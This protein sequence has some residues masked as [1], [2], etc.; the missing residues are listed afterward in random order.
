MEREDMKLQALSPCC[1]GMCLTA[2]AAS[3]WSARWDHNTSMGAHHQKT[4]SVPADYAGEKNMAI[5]DN[6]RN[7]NGLRTLICF[8]R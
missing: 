2:T 5:A 7:K 3:V 8:G 4:A 6:Y 1:R